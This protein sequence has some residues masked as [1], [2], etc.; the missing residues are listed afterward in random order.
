MANKYSRL[1]PK[2]KPL[3]FIIMGIIVVVIAVFII[4]LKPNPKKQFYQDY[5]IKRVAEDE[6]YLFEEVTVKALKKKNNKEEKMIVY[7][8]YSDCGN[9]QAE[10]K[11]YY[12]EFYKQNLNEDF[13]KIYYLN[14]RKVKDKD[15]QELANLGVTFDE[16]QQQINPFLIYYEEGQVKERHEGLGGEGFAAKIQTFYERV[17]AAQD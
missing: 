9:C 14:L 8:G 2:I 17:K 7:I 1:K 11:Y 5:N 10:V 16:Q 12:K 13:K 4:V 15:F 6:G 3:P